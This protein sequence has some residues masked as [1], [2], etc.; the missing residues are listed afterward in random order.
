MRSRDSVPD[1]QTQVFLLDS[2]G[3]MTAF[4][5]ASDIAFV[6]GSIARAGG[7][8]LLEPAAFGLPVL[9]GPHLFNTPETARLLS[10]A[11]ALFGVRD[12][13]E[14]AGRAARLLGSEQARRAAG[15]AAKACGN[16]GLGVLDRTL[17]LIEPLLPAPKT[18]SVPSSG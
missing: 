12:A 4:Y 10:D 6:G 14:L 1:A 5:A 15:Q 17:G 9:A 8:N 13:S 7:H 16:A 3:E 11:G 2:L 18:R